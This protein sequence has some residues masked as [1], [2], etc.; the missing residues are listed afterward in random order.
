MYDLK[1]KVLGYHGY[2]EFKH[3]MVQVFIRLFIG[4]RVMEVQLHGLLFII[5]VY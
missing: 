2:H 1:I 5:N 4:F 3:H